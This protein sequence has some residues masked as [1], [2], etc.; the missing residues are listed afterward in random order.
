MKINPLFH[1]Q[2]D[3]QTISFEENIWIIWKVVQTI[4]FIMCWWLTLDCRRHLAKLRV[5]DQPLGRLR[6]LEAQLVFCGLLEML[7]K[8]ASGR[9]KLKL[10]NK[11]THNW[12]IVKCN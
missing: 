8:L 1:R 12:L 11:N 10:T 4:R 7:I 9:Q 2:K 6:S 3:V 5:Y